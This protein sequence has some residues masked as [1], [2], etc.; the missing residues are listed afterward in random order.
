MDDKE[1]RTPLLSVD[2]LGIE[3]S[4]SPRLK[5]ARWN[6]ST[7]RWLRK[8]FYEKYVEVFKIKTS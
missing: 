5:I 7:A 6:Q 3:A 1:E 2:F 4:F 8:C